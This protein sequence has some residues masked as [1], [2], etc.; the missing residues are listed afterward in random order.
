VFQKMRAQQPEVVF[1][2]KRGNR[3]TVHHECL[4][5]GVQLGKVVLLQ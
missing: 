3:N 4:G 2:R 1:R 5:T